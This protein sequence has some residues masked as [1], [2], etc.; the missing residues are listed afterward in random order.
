MCNQYTHSLG[1]TAYSKY[2]IK[3]ASLF[4]LGKTSIPAYLGKQTMEQQGMY[5]LFN[6]TSVYVSNILLQDT[7]VTACISVNGST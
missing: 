7:C 1:R 5:N 6:F 4:L 2:N 3:T